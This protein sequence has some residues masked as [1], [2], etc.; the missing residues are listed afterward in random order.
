VRQHSDEEGGVE[1][2]VSQQAGCPPGVG[3]VVQG[4]GWLAW[5]KQGT[6]LIL[7]PMHQ[8]ASAAVWAYC[9]AAVAASAAPAAAE[10]GAMPL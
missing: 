7:E 10:C 3:A 6:G 2:A 5:G 1:A 4:V 9:L 8:A